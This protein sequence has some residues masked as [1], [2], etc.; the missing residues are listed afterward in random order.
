M[1]TIH[2]LWH[3]KNYAHE[4]TLVRAFEAERDAQ[5]IAELMRPFCSGEL[6]VEASS[7]APCTNLAPP[8]VPRPRDIDITPRAALL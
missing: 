1:R 7:L 5:D 4:W 8:I 6:K 3:K 2:I